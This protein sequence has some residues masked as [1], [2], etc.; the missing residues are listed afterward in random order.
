[1]VA[2]AG[3]VSTPTL[4]TPTITT[5]TTTAVLNPY[6]P[7]TCG[8]PGAVPAPHCGTSMGCV[9]PGGTTRCCVRSCVPDPRRLLA[10]SVPQ[11]AVI[12]GPASQAPPLSFIPD[13]VVAVGDRQGPTR[14]EASRTCAAASPLTVEVLTGGSLPEPAPLAERLQYVAR[15]LSRAGRE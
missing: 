3:Q 9:P 11:V 7:I 5:I 6:H 2:A 4:L 14:A 13:S 8:T 15:A 12:N 10:P 1:M